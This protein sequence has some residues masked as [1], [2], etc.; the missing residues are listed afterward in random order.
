M[1][2]HL[3]NKVV[4]VTG[5]SK[6]IGFSISRKFIEEGAKVIITGRNEEDL[7]SAVK[8][9][10]NSAYYYCVDHTDAD[11]IRGL[12]ALINKEFEQLDCI[13]CNV[14]SGKSVPPGSETIEEWVRVFDLNFFSATNVIETF[15]D[16]IITSKGNF[17]CISSIC[18]KETLEAPITY[19]VAKTALNNYVNNISK[20]L[21]KK[22]V[23]IN[24]ISPGNI[25]FE[26]SV[27]Q[28]KMNENANQTLEY[29]HEVVPL[30]KFGQAED[31]ANLA[32]FLASEKASFISGAN[33]I[34]DGGQTK[35]I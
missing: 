30:Q 20:V 2:L 9:M 34:I 29:I 26:G 21:G 10:G 16:A 17:I 13:V 8:K 7:V 14:G 5:A 23:R 32:V 6:G 25:L 19:S 31:I 27:W 24:V 3:S 11:S 35:S 22:G 1:N 18:G 15:K 33:F 12:R 4:L 28:R